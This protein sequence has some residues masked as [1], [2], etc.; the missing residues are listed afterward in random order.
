MI[1]QPG[2][3]KE[4]LKKHMERTASA[5]EEELLML[6]LDLYEEEELEQMIKEV[7]DG[8]PYND[9]LPEELKR[10]KP[11]AREIISRSRIS[12]LKK[13]RS[14]ISSQRSY[15]TYAATALLAIL[16]AWIFHRP[17][18]LEYACSA[19]TEESALI[20]P[21]VNKCK[22]ILDN[23]CAIVV[24]S[25]YTGEITRQGNTVLVR[26]P[27]GV[28]EY[29]S[30]GRPG[31]VGQQP[32]YHTIAT[33]RG[34]CHRI[35]LPNGVK[36]TLNAASSIRFP[37][38][39]T[40]PEYAIELKGEAYFES[41][42]QLNSPW[43]IITDYAR[44]KVAH[45]DFNVN[46]YDNRMVS[47]LS[48]GEL[49]ISTPGDNAMLQAGQQALAGHDEQNGLPGGIKVLSVDTREALSWMGPE[50]IFIHVAM[51]DFLLEMERRYDLDIV[52]ID[53]ASH[54]YFSG[55]LCNEAPLSELI[56]LLRANGLHF[57]QQGNT[58][59]FSKRPQDQEQ[60]LVSSLMPPLHEP[61]PL[62]MN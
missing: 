23:G 61:V 13:I 4:L 3:V 24:D 36:I 46:T 18:K 20:L 22:L 38:D 25:S 37:V 32:V 26:L 57:V 1:H 14:F 41:P 56:K 31:Q 59:I 2:Y 8:L 60:G 49:M 33:S 43:H 28:L 9:E 16:L 50:R 58:L 19:N 12:P 45:A 39:L 15:A 10:W 52:N 51:R 55:T 30:L 42:Q 44:I 11:S 47:T 5:H 53:R 27:S 29:K 21:G 35:L 17:S 54:R 7:S 40:S 62:G 48:A 6:A 34:A